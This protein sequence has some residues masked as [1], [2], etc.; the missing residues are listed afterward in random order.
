MEK[1]EL[2][3]FVWNAELILNRGPID[4]PQCLNVVCSATMQN[5]AGSYGDLLIEQNAVN[6]TAEQIGADPDDLI[7]VSLTWS[8]LHDGYE[9][10][11]PPPAPE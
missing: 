6:W 3:P 10:P 1:P 4:A 7:V 8:A 2:I 5:D 11:T 9:L